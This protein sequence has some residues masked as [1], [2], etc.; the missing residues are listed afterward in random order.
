TKK[1]FERRGFAFQDFNRYAPSDNRVSGFIAQPI[2]DK[3]EQIFSVVLQLSPEGINKFMQERTG[4]GKTG[5]SY[6]VG[7]DFLMRSD[8]IQDPAHKLQASFDNPQTG[9]V[10]TIA[11]EEGLQGKSGNKSFLGYTGNQVLASYAPVSVYGDTT[12]VVISKLD[13]E[14]AFAPVTALTRQMQ[15]LGIV[16]LAVV[17]L[18]ALWVASSISKPIVTM[19]NIITQ[20]AV[21]RDL[22]LQVPGGGN[23]EIGTMT[24]AFNNMIQVIHT[25]FK[26]VSDSAVK[27]AANA[28]DVAKRASGNRERATRELQRTKEATSLIT[29][30]GGTAGKVSQASLAQKDA[31]ESSA[32]TI[33]QLLK[34]V[35]QVAESANLQN[36]EAKETMGKVSEMGATGA[37]VVATAREQGTMVAKVS[38]AIA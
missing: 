33:S 37:K 6:L 32:K 19:A 24:K 34:A 13:D 1:A 29:E 15:I 9:S 12:W 5:E 4:L 2:I 28:D 7:S 18:I 20:I 17:V 23:D 14:E 26:V 27:V 8:S 35:E 25:A 31:A 36:K 21:N 30:M 16:I 38:S 11:V 22:T 3:G 10:K